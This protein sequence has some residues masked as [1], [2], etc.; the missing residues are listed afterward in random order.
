MSYDEEEIGLS[1]DFDEEPLD[2]PEGLDGDDDSK[3]EDPDDKF[4]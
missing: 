1:D 2:M 4:H 3:E